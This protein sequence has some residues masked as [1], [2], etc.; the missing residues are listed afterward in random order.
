MALYRVVAGYTDHHTTSPNLKSVIKHEYKAGVYAGGVG[1]G[2]SLFNMDKFPF[3]QIGGFV[4]TPEG[5]IGK[6]QLI[7]NLY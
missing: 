2:K 3:S 5:T 1:T 7:L 4:V 6:W